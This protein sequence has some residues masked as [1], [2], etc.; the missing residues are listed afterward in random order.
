[1]LSKAP[2][3]LATLAT[4]LDF[5]A[6]Q[7]PTRDLNAKECTDA[8]YS[9]YERAPPT[10]PPA[11]AEWAQKARSTISETWTTTYT[12][13]DP[14]FVVTAF[15][16]DLVAL[17]KPTPPASVSAAWNSYSSALYEWR[18][19][20]APA[21][22]SIA[23]ACVKADSYVAENVLLMIATDYQGCTSALNV[24]KQDQTSS[25]LDATTTNSPGA[26]AK[27]N[28]KG[29]IAAAP[30]TATSTG[31]GVAW[32]KETRGCVA[33]AVAAAAVAGVIGA[34]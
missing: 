21:A 9:L 2:L 23:S 7:T 6:A 32:A 24:G 5:V 4:F 11:L 31:G 17:P 19:S 3:I 34:M 13:G 8:Y 22:V 25:T 18:E 30:S 28:D 15:C 10:A 20:I 12:R 29:G 26:V 27:Q 16:S 33:A 1:M 14:G